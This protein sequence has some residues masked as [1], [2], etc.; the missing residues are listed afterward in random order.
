MSKNKS[1]DTFINQLLAQPASEFV[2]FARYDPDGDCIEFFMKPDPYFGERV[3]GA[4]T[5]FRSRESHEIVGAH[6][7]RTDQRR[8]HFIRGMAQSSPRDSRKNRRSN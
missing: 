8:Q 5:V 2:P 3:D 7:E 6:V 1:Y 4:L